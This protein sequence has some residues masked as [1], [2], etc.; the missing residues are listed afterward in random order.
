MKNRL[1]R[2]FACASLF[3]GLFALQSCGVYSFT[4]TTLSADLKSITIQ[5]FTMS[6]A[7]GPPNLTLD[8]NE[9]LKEYYQRNTNLKLLPSNGDLFLAGTITRYEMTPL[10]TTASDKAAMNRLTI[11]VDVSFQNAQDEKQNFEKEF[12]F[13]QDF[14]QEQSL[15]DV[16]PS[17]VPKILEQLVLNIFNDTAAQ[18]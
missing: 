12:S 5:N 15:S 2:I 14:S 3:M 6:T 8:F 18:W 11:A 4:G 7:G 1:F 13:Y 9:S 17:L 10:A 16:E